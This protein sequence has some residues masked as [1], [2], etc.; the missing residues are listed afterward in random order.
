LL[1]LALSKAPS[2][3]HLT[4]TFTRLSLRLLGALS[5][6]LLILSSVSFDIEI[7]IHQL[8]QGSFKNKG[9]LITNKTKENATGHAVTSF[10]WLNLTRKLLIIWQIRWPSGTLNCSAPRDINNFDVIVCTA[11]PVLNSLIKICSAFVSVFLKSA[12]LLKSSGRILWNF[13]P[14][15]RYIWEQKA[16]DWFLCDL[17]LSVHYEFES[18]NRHNWSRSG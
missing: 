6:S 12:R 1:R 17:L 14:R 7:F 2:V 10:H 9:A 8:L 18:D 15:D 13:R 11:D 3:L 4:R 5:Y 16:V